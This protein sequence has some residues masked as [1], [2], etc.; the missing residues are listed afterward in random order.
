MS[1]HNF[2]RSMFPVLKDKG[3]SSILLLGSMSILLLTF[4]YLIP[5]IYMIISL[6][7][8]TSNFVADLNFLLTDSRIIKAFWF[9]IW[10]AII[11]TILSVLIGLP[12]AYVFSHYTFKGSRFL[13]SL[14]TIP[15]LLPPI[16]VVMGMIVVYGDNG[17]INTI[18]RSNL[19]F[20]PSIEVY[21]TTGI[22]LAH[23]FYNT[24]III[25]IVSVMWESLD[26]RPLEIAETL[27][28]SKIRRFIRLELP[29]LK[30]AILSSSL[31]IFLYCFTSFAIV[32]SFGGLEVRT[33][34]V[35][36]YRFAYS[37]PYLDFA[38]AST[39]A[40]IQL[41]FLSLF[42][43]FYYVIT[44]KEIS[45][46]KIGF[47]PKSSFKL[48]KITDL[49]FLSLLLLF[50]IFILLPI[51]AVV[52][53]S[54]VNRSGNYT[55]ENFFLLFSNN[56][57]SLIQ[58]SFF[59]LLVN[60]LFIALLTVILSLVISLG[61][62]ILIRYWKPLKSWN[63]YNPSHS[64]F[65]LVLMFPLASS[66]LLV[67]LGL[68]SV[69]SS[70][71]IYSDYNV[72]VIIIAHSIAALPISS[73]ILYSSFSKLN[74]NYGQVG[75]TLGAN[76]LQILMKIEIPLILKS[77]VVAS[78]FSF[79]I[80]LGEFGATLF[81]NPQEFTTL[82]IAIYRLLGTRDLGLPSAMATILIALCLVSFLLI[83][84]LSEKESVI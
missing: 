65:Q 61:I 18:L 56:Y 46:K 12:I 75:A 59:R 51:F 31:L 17:I 23:V 11:S 22:I 55:I 66:G 6:M 62:I 67:A 15:F 35:Q 24:P 45:Q 2:A 27:G 84:Y 8:D 63:N 77:I 74:T 64:K 50:S 81:I 33:L 34:E 21:S 40:F 73:R 47:F 19:P 7:L 60:T 71:A 20:M 43:I 69:F 53:H 57:D 37:L 41:I 29:Q 38:L 49:I 44:K 3:F 72:I 30:F 25:R 28:A 32:L 76:K 48:N 78:L 80:S 26:R 79:A 54:F 68:Y 1:I 9:S 52:F 82:G 16:V 5:I 36:I 70:T 4:F 14:L 58:T 39:L 13:K 10:Q 42:I 83:D